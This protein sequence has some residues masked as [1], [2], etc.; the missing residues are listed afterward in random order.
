MDKQRPLCIFCCFVSL[1]FKKYNADFIRR[2][3]DKNLQT[4]L[5]FWVPIFNVLATFMQRILIQYAR[6]SLHVY[7]NDLS[8]LS[9]MGGGRGQRLHQY[10]NLRKVAVVEK[11]WLIMHCG[12]LVYWMVQLK[13]QAFHS[14]EA[15]TCVQQCL[16]FQRSNSFFWCWIE[17]LLL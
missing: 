7:E 5:A 11:L 15:I 13:N 6:Q 4:F 10:N 14:A 9:K 8:V 12:Y 3:E 16:K 2:L 1:Q 17:K